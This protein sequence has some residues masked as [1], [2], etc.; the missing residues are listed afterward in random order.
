M[1]LGDVSPVAS[2]VRFVEAARPGRFRSCLKKRGSELFRAIWTMT[3]SGRCCC[4][5][6][7]NHPT[8]AFASDDGSFEGAVRNPKMCGRALLHA[9]RNDTNAGVRLKALEA[10]DR[11]LPTGTRHAL[12]EVLL[13]DDNPGVRTQAIDLLTAA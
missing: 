2:R 12:A 8:L 1:A 9:L 5:R 11:P 13:K 3:A 10:F 4:A 7:A 6:R